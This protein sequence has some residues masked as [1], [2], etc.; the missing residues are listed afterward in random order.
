MFRNRGSA[1][2]HFEKTLSLTKKGKLKEASIEL[3]KA[4]EAA[5]KA[6]A[7]DILLSLQIIKGHL[8]QTSGEHEEALKIY[9]F[10]LKTVEAV[11]SK[12]PESEFYQS[13]LQTNLEAIF[14]LGCIFHNMGHFLQSKNCYDLTLSSFQK[15]LK[16]DPQNAAY[17]SNAAMTLNNFGNLLKDMG[18]VQ[19]AKDRY[20]KAL[21]IYEDLCKADPKNLAHQAC[22]GTTSNNLGAMLSDLGRPE[23]A[24]ERYEMALNIYEK[25]L[26]TDPKN[27]THQ[28]DAAM[29]L[30]NIGILLSDRNHFDEA[31]D[32]YEKALD[33]YEKL[34][35]KD[36]KNLA[37]LSDG[38]KTLNN[39]G[40]LA[41]R[42][43]K[44]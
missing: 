24:T 44:P 29:T 4:E 40:E 32:R 26:K 20:E 31:K 14:T 38:A 30:N 19:E 2:K 16:T 42:N 13:I 43:G 17:Q 22:A 9:S 36:P 10:A 21:A 33:I 41:S 12:D 15:L 35:K 34:V 27:V 3:E 5:Q 25:L 37:Y 23:E 28:S 7:D 1:K 18:R 39:L 6:N 8:M 11:L